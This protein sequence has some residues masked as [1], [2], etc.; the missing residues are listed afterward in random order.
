LESR[1]TGSQRRL[2]PQPDGAQFAALP[3]LEPLLLP[4]PKEES[5]LFTDTLP[6]S[7]QRISLARL[8]S[9]SFSNL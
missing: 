1:A 5:A 9:T 4:R 6:H 2:T 8:D 7:G 3:I